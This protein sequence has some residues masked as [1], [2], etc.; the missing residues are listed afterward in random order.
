MRI[1]DS[2]FF[3]LEMPYF[4]IRRR[5]GV[6]QH[7]CRGVSCGS[8]N[9]FHIAAGNH[10]LIGHT[11]V[12][13]TVK[14]DSHPPHGLVDTKR[15]D[16]ICGIKIEIF[17]GQTYDLALSQCAHQCEVDCQMQDGILLSRAARISSTVQMVRSCVDFLGLSTGTG[18]LTRMPHSTAYWKA[19]PSKPE[20]IV[21]V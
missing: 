1:A 20:V 6:H 14:Y 8:L 16:A 11:G 19:V 4:S 10:Q 2:I 18:L 17:R 3:S 7:I 12:P 15:S 21:Q 9:S 13:Q 5:I